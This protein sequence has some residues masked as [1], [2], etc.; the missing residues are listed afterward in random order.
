MT[1]PSPRGIDGVSGFLGF[2]W[3][4][5]DTLAITVEEHHINAAG[6]LS[7]AVTFA[8]IDY[9]MGSALWSQTAEDEHIATLSISINYVQTATEGEIV[10]KSTVDRRNDRIAVLRSEVH[11][12]DGRLLATAI[13]S[14]SIFPPRGRSRRGDTPGADTDAPG[15]TVE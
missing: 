2:R 14:Y 11:A 3:K 6:L 4:A 15:H 8:M 9:C 5:P 12:A 10:C 13:G 7:G 1:K